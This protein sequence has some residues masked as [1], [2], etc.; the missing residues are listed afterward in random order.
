MCTR[1]LATILS[2][3]GILLLAGCDLLQGPADTQ[4][5]DNDDPAAQV[6]GQVEMLLGSNGEDPSER[7]YRVLLDDDSDPTNGAVEEITGTVPGSAGDGNVISQF[8]Y[9]ID[10]VAPGDY[11]LF[12]YFDTNEDG[13]WDGL[14]GADETPDTPDDEY[15]N[16]FGLPPDALWNDAA[17]RPSGP[18]LTVPES[19]FVT[20]YVRLFLTPFDTPG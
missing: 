19:G 11:Y 6:I 17:A 10:D 18:S 13:D 5:T 3:L 14:A 1:R 12:V 7:P 4:D 16:Y 2:V 20:A 9:E 15:A 8:T